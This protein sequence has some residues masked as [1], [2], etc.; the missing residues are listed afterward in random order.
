[1][2]MVVLKIESAFLQTKRSA[3]H[4]AAHGG[5]TV[6]LLMVQLLTAR[7]REYA[8]VNMDRRDETTTDTG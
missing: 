3:M 5:R 8:S 7:Q 4:S 2:G 1:M 6:N